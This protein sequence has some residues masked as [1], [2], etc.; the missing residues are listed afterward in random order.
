MDGGLLKF[1]HIHC[2][3]SYDCANANANCNCIV[4]YDCYET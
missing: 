4:H 3:E 2:C 1:G